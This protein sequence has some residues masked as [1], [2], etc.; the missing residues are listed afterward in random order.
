LAE[1]WSLIETFYNNKSSD[2]GHDTSSSGFH[3]DRALQ[4]D[5]WEWLTLNPEVSIGHNKEYNGLSLS[6]AEAI[7]ELRLFVSED[8]TWKA[9]TGHEKD[10]SKVPATEFL[11]LSIIA[12]CRS[13]GILQ[14]E[15]VRR[16]GQDARSVPKRTDALRTKG[17]IDKRQV[18]AKSAKTSLCTLSRFAHIGDGDAEGPAAKSPQSRDMIDFDAF[19]QDIFRIL[20]KYQIIAR[21]D[22][23]DEL[24]FGDTWRRRILS[25][26]IRKLE[27]I[28]CVQRVKARSQFHDTMDTLHPCVLLVREPTEFDLK[29][30]KS[31]YKTILSATDQENEEVDEQAEI[32]ALDRRLIQWTPDANFANLIA[33]LIRDSGTA[34]RTNAEVI[35]DG[36]GKIFRRPSENTLN[37]IT[38]CWQLSQPSHLRSSAIVRDTALNGTVTHY[39]HYSYSNFKQL[40]DTGRADWEAVTFRPRDTKSSKLAMPPPDALPTTDQDGLAPF[41]PPRKG[42]IERDH[43]CTVSSKGLGSYTTTKSDP[44][45]MTNRSGDFGKSC[46]TGHK[47]RSY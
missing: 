20:K 27:T 40:V 44:I 17:Y 19:C 41:R 29:L 32:Q 22:L 5:L 39:I 34:G 33:C 11:L 24:G 46:S 9:L 31:D 30:F 43:Y 47:K 13:Q 16:S 8:R 37:R 28:G 23:K 3:L 1:I 45:P 15:L 21:S 7:S 18:Q 26:A 10:E 36:F 42:L 2:A 12:S 38:E 25:R 14:T 35:R 6:E 4:E